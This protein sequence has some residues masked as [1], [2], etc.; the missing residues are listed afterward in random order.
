M[1][2]N[3]PPE[4]GALWADVSEMMKEMGGQQ[5]ILLTKKMRA[6]ERAAERRRQRLKMY[7]EEL[8]YAGFVFII[9]I[10][11]T[12]LMAYISHDRKQRWPELEPEAIAQRRHEK[13]E[14]LKAQ[15]ERQR[16]EEAEASD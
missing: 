12:L 13:L 4:L 11:V 1:I 5:K 7:A 16:R 3:S 14:W 15:E 10:T 9:G 8:T 2:Y 6:D